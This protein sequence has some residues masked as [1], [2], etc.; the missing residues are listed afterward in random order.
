[1]MKVEI[2]VTSEDVVNPHVNGHDRVLG[3][4]TLR[5]GEFSKCVTSRLVHELLGLIYGDCRIV[6]KGTNK[7]IPFHL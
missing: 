6:F 1:M 3:I 5:T 4:P 7:E 2:S